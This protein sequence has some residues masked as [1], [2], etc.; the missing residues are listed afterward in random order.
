MNK[1]EKQRKIMHRSLNSFKN[2]NIFLNCEYKDII[3]VPYP[4]LTTIS[5]LILGVYALC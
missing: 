4:T 5:F 3:I 2:I 1:R